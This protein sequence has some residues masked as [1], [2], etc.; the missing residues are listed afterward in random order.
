MIRECILRNNG[1][2]GWDPFG[3]QICG[4][5]GLQ[6]AQSRETPA[7]QGSI[8]LV[9]CRRLMTL[10]AE[11]QTTDNSE[12]R[13]AS[14]VAQN[15][16]FLVSQVCLQQAM[17]EAS[18]ASQESLPQAICCTTQTHHVLFRHPMPSLLPFPDYSLL[19]PPLTLADSCPPDGLIEL[20]SL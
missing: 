9:S 19:I 16:C 2:S 8:R 7:G 12:L 17:T 4:T 6:G 10:M 5:G 1:G 18:K 3:G 15:V 14:H 11:L 20:M 13:K